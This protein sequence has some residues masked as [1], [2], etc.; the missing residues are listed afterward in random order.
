MAMRSSGKGS[1]GGTGSKNV[2]RPTVKYGQAARAMREKGV[3]QIGTN[4]GNHATGSGK[5]LRGDVDQM[6]FAFTLREDADSW[7]VQEDESVIR[8]LHADGA[9]ELLVPEVRQAADQQPDDRGL[10]ARQRP[11]DR[12]GLVA[13]LRGRGA[14]TLLGLGR[15]VHAAQRV[16]DGS[17]RQARVLG[18]LT[19][20]RALPAARGHRCKRTYRLACAL[21][22]RCPAT[23]T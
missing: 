19:D 16:A 20:R 22:G 7:D 2:V 10:A 3:S 12:V 8:T 11:G 15:H 18:E 23:Y 4:R 13:E 9:D 6:S 14:D 17:G 1:G 5:M 21:T